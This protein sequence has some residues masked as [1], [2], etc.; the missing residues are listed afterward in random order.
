MRLRIFGFR[1]P[2]AM[3]AAALALASQPAAAREAPRPAVWLL[4]D[5]DTSIYLL[6]TVH[7]LPPGYSWRSETVERLT[8]EADE[9]VVEDYDPPGTSPGMD[10]MLTDRTSP[11]LRRVPQSRRPALAAAVRKS[12]MPTYYYDSLQSWAAAMMLDVALSLKSMGVDDSEEAPGVEDWLETQFRAAGKP[13]GSVEDS[14][15]VLVALSGMPEKAQIQMLLMVADHADDEDGFDLDLAHWRAGRDETLAARPGVD[16]PAEAYDI[17]LTRRNAAWAEWLEARLERPGTVL[18]A[19]GAAHLAGEHSV[20]KML[21][22]R[23]L[24]AKRY[25]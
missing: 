21:A 2:A 19:V 20:Q 6:G 5:E 24:A 23:G 7:M 11:L 25:D 9:L 16:F 22:A 3:L 15:K 14:E 1:A 10:V 17:L 12:G 8:R 4:A 18:F 13:I